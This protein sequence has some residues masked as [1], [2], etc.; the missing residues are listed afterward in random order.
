MCGSGT[1]A[2]CT[3]DGK[4]TSLAYVLDLPMNAEDSEACCTSPSGSI[5]SCSREQGV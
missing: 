1:Y 2:I 3:P 5:Y 4:K